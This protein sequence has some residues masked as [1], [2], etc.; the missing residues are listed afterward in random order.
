MADNLHGL[1]RTHFCGALRAEDIGKTVTLYGWAG[2]QRDLG[3]LVFIDLRARTG[4]TQLAF[5]ESTEKSIFEKAQAVRSEYVLA[6]TGMVRERS[7]K[8][9]EIPTGDIEIAVTDL[10]VLSKSETP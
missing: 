3:A 4:I 6:A 9:K 1:K 7:S 8:N 5:D 10:R 2:K